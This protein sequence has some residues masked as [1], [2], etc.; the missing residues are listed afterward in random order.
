MLQ[1]TKDFLPILQLFCKLGVLRVSF[2]W[3]SDYVWFP[4]C[5]ARWGWLRSRRRPREAFGITPSIACHSHWIP[6][7]SS[8]SLSPVCQTDLKKPAH[9]HC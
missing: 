3:M 1:N 8:S 4:V 6:C 7:K 2:E 5:R 9:S